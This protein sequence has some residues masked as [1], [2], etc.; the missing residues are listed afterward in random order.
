MPGNIITLDID[1]TMIDK[2]RL[3]KG[4]KPNKKQVLP[5]YLR[6]VLLPSKPTQYGDRRDDQTH[7]VVQS[8]SKEEKDKGIRGEILGNAVERT[9]VDRRAPST[10]SAASATPAEPAEDSTD[11][12]VPF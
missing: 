2:A 3:V 6:L 4:K 11:D 9:G 5:Q 8:V 10:E 12:D 1:V 7:M